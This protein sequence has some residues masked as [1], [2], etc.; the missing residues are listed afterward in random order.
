M[1]GLVPLAWFSSPIGSECEAFQSSQLM[2][3]M[4]LP[5]PTT[6]KRNIGVKC[7]ISECVFFCYMKEKESLS[8][9]NVQ[10]FPPFSPKKRKKRTC[11]SLVIF[12]SYPFLSVL[13]CVTYG[14]CISASV[15][16]HGTKMILVTNGLLGV[17]C[18]CLVLMCDF[19]C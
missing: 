7:H 10:L 18:I 9:I 11:Y 6:L 5:P 19:G 4:F 17:T 15:F 2:S 3:Y 16:W 1:N 8:C 13:V 14:K 12:P